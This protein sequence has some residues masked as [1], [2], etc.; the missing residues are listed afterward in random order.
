[1]PEAIGPGGIQLDPDQPVGDWAEAT[2]R[3]WRD[4]ARYAA[5]SAAALQHAQRKEISFDHQLAAW[6]RVITGN[7]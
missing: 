4:E 3:L 2:R 5:L 1:L 7:R 6:E